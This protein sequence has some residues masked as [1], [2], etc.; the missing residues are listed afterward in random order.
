MKTNLI[1]QAVHYALLAGAALILTA[2]AAFAQQAAQSNATNQNQNQNAN[3]E[4]GRVLVTGSAI[5]RTSVETPAPVTV[6]TAKQIQESGLSTISDVIRSISADNSGTIPEAFSAG[7]AGGS[8]GVALRGLTVNSTLVL[9]DGRRTTGYPLADDGIR[10]FTDLNT[11]PLNA[12]ERIE[13]LKDGASSI[14]GADA[15][16]G[17]I[18]IILYPS[19]TGSR[20]TAT[21]GG[22]QQGGGALQDYT[23]L[24]GTGNLDTNGWNAYLSV[25]YQTQRQ[26]YSHDRGFPLSACDTSSL[27]NLDFCVGGNPAHG[28]PGV[29]SSTG[30]AGIGGSI[31]GVVAPAI[32]TGTNPDGTPNLLTGSVI[33]GTTFQS[34]RTCPTP[35][36]YPGTGPGT[37]TGCAYNEVSAYGE[38]AP[39]TDNYSIDGRI[40]VNLNPTTTAYLNASF[41]QSRMVNAVGSSAEGGLP[42]VYPGI[43]NV[44]PVNTTNIV[45]PPLLPNGTLNPNDP[46]ATAAGCASLTS[47]PGPNVNIPGCQYA[48]I[49]YNFGDL[50]LF[51]SSVTVNHVMRMEADVNGALSENWNYDAGLTL[52]HASLDYTL[53]GFLNI[54]QLIRDV[55]DGT[56]N[57]VNPSLNSQATRDAL[58]PPDGVTASTDEDEADFS[59][60]GTLADLPGG[61][62]ALAAGTQWRYEAQYDP[63]LNPGEIYLGLGNAKTVGHRNVAALYSELDAPVLNSLEMDLSMRDDHYSD[64]GSAFSPKFGIKWTPIQQLMLRGT[65]SRGFRA[66]SFSENGSSSSLGFANINPASVSPAFVNQHCAAGVPPGTLTNPCTPDAYAQSYAIGTLNEANPNIQPERA[67]NYTLG[68]VFQPVSGFSGTLDYYNILKTNVI[69]PPAPAN[70]IG[71]YFAGSP[72]PPGSVILDVPDPLHPTSMLRPLQFNADYV[73]ENELRTSGFDLELRYSQD[74]SGFNW[75]SDFNGTK[76]LTWCET[77]VNGGPCI[78]MVGTQGPFNLSSGAGT[79]KFRWNWA[80]TFTMGPASVTATVYWVS[81]YNMTIPDLAP[82]GVCASVG[83]LGTQVPADC[84]VPAFYYIDL[85][86][87]YHINDNWS[88]TAGILNATNK[89]PPFDPIDYAGNYYS[90]TYAQQGAVGRFYQVGLQIKF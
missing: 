71:Q 34:L 1:T 77:L 48:K 69:E 15:I 52:N 24:T 26:I 64:F 41:N 49:A 37:G 28:G 68:M 38:L 14:Y 22:S 89:S 9:I 51:G 39:Q 11:I 5:P 67:R 29:G 74:F 12:V 88:L 23:F 58:A 70:L 57:F 21:I 76:I 82:P 54:P 56:Y 84:G 16:A 7:F 18:N 30:S 19:W 72:L 85:T 83:Y 35:V 10:W 87:I 3:V 20:A 43:Q 53:Y 25:E 78:S 59:V 4:L 55:T 27:G 17:V 42:P 90:P 8:T 86:G 62:L 63:S 79:P 66:P 40:T 75:T 44:T 32:V 46:F 31:Y 13:V 6:I 33:P 47:N 45:L 36:T 2:P 80:N 61:P 50:P 60:N 65:Y 81:R 73:N